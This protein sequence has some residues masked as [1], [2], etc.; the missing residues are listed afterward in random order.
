VHL[1]FPGPSESLASQIMGF[2]AC[3]ARHV[4]VVQKD[5]KGPDEVANEDIEAVAALLKDSSVVEISEDGFQIRRK[6]VRHACF[7]WM[8]PIRCF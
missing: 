2:I 1:S 6:N 7:R 8:L 3:E 4:A 5:A